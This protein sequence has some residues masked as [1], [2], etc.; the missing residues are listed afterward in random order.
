VRPL[1]LS[2]SSG[3]AESGGWAGDERFEAAEWSAAPRLARTLT[4]GDGGAKLGVAGCGVDGPYEC[5]CGECENKDGAQDMHGG[6]I[7]WL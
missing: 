6:S 2:G 1:L 3:H 7:L 5:R 4:G